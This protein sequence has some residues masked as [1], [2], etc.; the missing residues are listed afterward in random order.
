MFSSSSPVNNV[1]LQPLRDALAAL[2]SPPAAHLLML[3][4]DRLLQTEHAAQLWMPY[5]TTEENL[6]ATV[7][8]HQPPA[9]HGDGFFCL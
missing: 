3:D 8:G 5:G 6:E 9:L 2:G 1:R 4:A 7:S